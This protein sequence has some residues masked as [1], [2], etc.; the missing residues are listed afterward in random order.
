MS[1]TQPPP[2]VE[3]RHYPRRWRRGRRA[4]IGLLVLLVLGVIGNLALRRIGPPLLSRLSPTTVHIGDTVVLEGQGFDS[5]LEGNVVYFGDYSGRVLKAVHDLLE[6]EV[7]DVGVAVG[8][9]QRLPVK[10]E[11]DEQK[12]TNS[13]ELVIL[14]PREEEPGTESLTEE[15]E[16]VPPL[17]SPNPGYASPQATPRGLSPSP[18]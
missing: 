7:P 18:R 17:A 16:E 3:R 5:T 6:V 14:P 15:E 9:E 8:A 12:V 10:V 11:V 13:L 1:E 4:V 2:A